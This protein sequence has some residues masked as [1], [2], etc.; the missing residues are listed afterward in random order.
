MARRRFQLSEEQ[1]KELTMAYATCK[2][3]P[4]RTRFQAVRLYGIGYPVVQIMDITGCSRTSLMEWCAAYRQKE[5]TALMDQRRGGNRARLTKG[6]IQDL[7]SRLHTHTPGDL[8]G[9]RAA[10]LDGQFWTIPD[11][12]QALEQWYGVSYQSR[13]SYHRYFDL[14]GFSYQRP[15]KVY[16][17][18]SQAQVAEFEAQLEKN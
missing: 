6:Q 10:T 17:S 16:Q 7:K 5:S 3:G 18:R 9:S 4:T 2:D 11:L 13:G 1:I 12:Q 8:F 15:A 14:C